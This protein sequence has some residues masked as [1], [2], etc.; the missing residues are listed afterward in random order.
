MP[1]VSAFLLPAS[2]LPY[3]NRANPPWGAAAEAMEKT[4]ELLDQSNPDTLLVYSTGWFA[5]LDQLWQTRDH[6]SGTHVDENWHEYG[7]LEFDIYSDQEF[8]LACVDEANARGIKSKPVDYDSFPI[9]TGTIVATKFLN[10]TKNRP[11]VIA[12][13]NLY[14]GPDETANIAHLAVEVG[15][16]LNRR[17]AVVAIGGLS[18]AFFRD[19]IDII[20][21]K[22]ADPEDDDWNRRLLD[23]IEKAN[24]GELQAM[25]PDYAKAAKADM[26]MKH[27]TFLLAALGGTYS[28]ADVLHYGPIYGA[29]TAVIAFTP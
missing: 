22:I 8:A 5:V 2:P 18:G 20:Q 24:A 9:D 17:M 15:N 23:A 25:L 11:L 26:G 28:A 29:G 12:S 7:A 27:L 19:N 4:G 13:N 1:V 21:D 3:L 10:K 16:R 14:H 6:L